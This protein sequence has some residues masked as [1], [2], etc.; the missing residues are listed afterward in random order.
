MLDICAET[1][2]MLSL[3]LTI[4]QTARTGGRL[5]RYTSGY[6]IYFDHVSRRAFQ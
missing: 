3:Q 1:C 2:E 5:K 4:L 6:G